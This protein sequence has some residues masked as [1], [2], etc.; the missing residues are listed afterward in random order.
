M[1]KIIHY[2]IV[3]EII[4]P[5]LDI[6]RRRRQELNTLSRLDPKTDYL[7]QYN[8]LI[9]YILLFLLTRGFDLKMGRVHLL[10]RE[11]CSELP[12][13]NRAMVNNI[14]QNRHQNKYSLKDAND[15]ARQNLELIIAFLRNEMNC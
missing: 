3:A 2:L 10:V 9:R 14:I 13:F 8:R 15:T 7:S 11:F 4:T 5:C 6:N 1:N 12:G